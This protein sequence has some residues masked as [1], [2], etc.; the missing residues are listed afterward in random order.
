MF[1]FLR[2]INE[3]GIVI[4]FMLTINPTNWYLVMQVLVQGLILCLKKVY[5]PKKIETTMETLT[6][7]MYD[8][9]FSFQENRQFLQKIGQNGRKFTSTPNRRILF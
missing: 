3:L 4:S 6:L 5:L 9:N 1:A 2:S 7:I 8:H